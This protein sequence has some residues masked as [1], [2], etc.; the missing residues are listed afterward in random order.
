MTRQQYLEN[1]IADLKRFRERELSIPD[2][3]QKYIDDLT[4]SIA[5]LEVQLMKVESATVS[6][7]IM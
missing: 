7:A 3:S 1:R 5:A 2:K 6:T 4:A